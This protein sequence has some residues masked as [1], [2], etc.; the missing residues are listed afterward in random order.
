[1]AKLAPNLDQATLMNLTA[2][3]ADTSQ[4]L[5]NLGRRL[6]LKIRRLFTG[7]GAVLIWE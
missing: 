1:L 3:P 6:L 2:N 4:W 7:A 5:V